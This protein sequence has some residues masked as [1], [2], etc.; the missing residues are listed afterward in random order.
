[1][2]KRELIIQLQKLIDVI[3]RDET[4]LDDVNITEQPY[5]AEVYAGALVESH[6]EGQRYV[7]DFDVKFVD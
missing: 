6:K 5:Y 3:E 2:D 4:R 1:M 7:V